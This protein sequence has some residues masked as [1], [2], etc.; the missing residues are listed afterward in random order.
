[1]RTTGALPTECPA[2]YGT[3]HTRECAPVME[4]HYNREYNAYLEVRTIERGSGC[5]RCGGTGQLRAP[6][7]NSVSIGRSNRL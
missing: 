3:G 5:L 6:G 2:C 1:M 7:T 4:T